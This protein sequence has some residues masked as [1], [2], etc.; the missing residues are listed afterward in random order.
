MNLWLIIPAKPFEEGKSRLADTLLHYERAAVNQNLLT[1]V[2]NTTVAADIFTN[3]IVISRSEQV[4]TYARSFGAI[5]LQEDDSELSTESSSF[6]PHSSHSSTNL[7]WQ[8]VGS[9][10]VSPTQH[11]SCR[12]TSVFAPSHHVCISTKH[13]TPSTPDISPNNRTDRS[14]PRG[15]DG[16][17]RALAQATAEAISRGAEAV[18]ILPVDLPLLSVDDIH[19]LYRSGRRQQGIV[20]AR[21]QDGGTNALLLRPPNAIQFAF[22]VQSCQRHFAAA[23]AA[24]YPCEVLDSPSLA[25]DLDGPTDWQQWQQIRECTGQVMDK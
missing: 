13:P 4:L 10:Q 5:T 23:I 17:N 21:S 2:L 24:G 15:E 22:G 11:V 8:Q 19:N 1:H 25:F 6:P 16:L 12:A 9:A 18:L 20:I 14:A 3:T 7:T